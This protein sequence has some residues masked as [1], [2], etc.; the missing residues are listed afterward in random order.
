[1]LLRTGRIRR[2]GE[3]RRASAGG[4]E[5]EDGGSASGPKIATATTRAKVPKVISLP[6]HAAGTFAARPNPG[7][8][9]RSV[10]SPRRAKGNCRFWAELRLNGFPPAGAARKFLSL[11]PAMGFDRSFF[12]TLASLLQRPGF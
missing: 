6:V 2:P 12:G 1:V 3:R 4:G 10:T 9:A 5:A 8:S 7:E 11:S